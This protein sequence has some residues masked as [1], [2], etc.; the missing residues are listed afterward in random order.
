MSG[1][2]G[3]RGQ[4]ARRGARTEPSCGWRSKQCESAKSL[5]ASQAVDG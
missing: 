2:A 3:S 5:D 4:N 1:D